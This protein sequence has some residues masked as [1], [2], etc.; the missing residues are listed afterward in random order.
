MLKRKRNIYV[1]QKQK[2]YRFVSEQR[3]MRVKK[4]LQGATTLVG[5]LSF[6]LSQAPM[7]QASESDTLETTQGKMEEQSAKTATVPKESLPLQTNSDKENEHGSLDGLGDVVE[8]E[9]P[10]DKSK[11]EEPGDTEDKSKTE[12]PEDTEDKSKTE[13]HGDTEGKSKTEDPGNLEDKGNTGKP[14]NAVNPGETNESTDTEKSA[15]PQTPNGVEQIEDEAETVVQETPPVSIEASPIAQQS[16]VISTVTQSEV[17]ASSVASDGSIHFEKDESVETFIRKIGEPARKIGQENDLY[18][19]VMMAQAILESGSG[20]SE[21]SMA[22]NYNLFGIK[23]SYEGESV[24]FQ[25]QEDLGDGSMET[26]QD[27]FRKYNNYEESFSDYAKLLKEGIAGDCDFYSG[28]WKGNTTN[29]E[30][31]T[32]FLT[33][34]YATDTQYNQKLNGLIETYDLT[35]YDKPVEEGELSATGFGMPIKNYVISSPFGNRGG[36]FHRGLDM[37]A[38]QGEP[39]YA[40]KAGTVTTAEFHS[41]WG[42]YVVI[43]HEGGLSTLYAHQSQYVVQ[44]GDQVEQ[45]QIIGYVGSTGNSTGSHLHFEVCEDGSLSSDKLIDPETVLF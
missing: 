30:D 3:R 4:S 22:P 39:I 35:K 41:S 27:E 29:Y 42:N 9:N 28:T 5:S 45:G 26:I 25:T 21:L 33:G 32:K 17:P 1:K 2:N 8:T 12:E 15:T 23:G 34:R 40:S 37:A 20:S 31:A 18:A 43:S 11:T 14:G 38:A 24:S 10:E 44:P 36:E 16:P 7:V 6:F 13:E 19:S